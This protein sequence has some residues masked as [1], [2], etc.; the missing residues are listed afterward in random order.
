MRERCQQRFVAAYRLAITIFDL[1]LNAH[2]LEVRVFRGEYAA[3]LCLSAKSRT[4]DP[5]GD[6]RA[7]GPSGRQFINEALANEQ[8][9]MRILLCAVLV[10]MWVACILSYGSGASTRKKKSRSG[11]VVHRNQFE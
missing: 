11:S 9:Q 5:N 10:R 6:G 3:R 7:G 1:V 4:L 2:T 8:V